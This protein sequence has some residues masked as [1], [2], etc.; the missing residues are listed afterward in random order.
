LLA[1][2]ASFLGGYLSLQYLM[3]CLSLPFPPGILSLK[4]AICFDFKQGELSSTASQM[5]VKIITPVAAQNLPLLKLTNTTQ[6]TALVYW[7]F[8][9]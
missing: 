5:N 8:Q 7:K 9:Q 1:V 6:Y 2:E 3:H 4:V